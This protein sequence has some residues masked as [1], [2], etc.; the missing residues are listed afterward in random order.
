MS[1]RDAY[2]SSALQ[3][4]NKGRVI[5]SIEQ[6]KSLLRADA[7]NGGAYFYLSI[8][9]TQMSELDAAE[10]YLRRAMEL[11][12]NQASHYYQLGVIRYR[13]KQW[14]AALGFFNQALQFKPGSNE[15]AVWRSIGDVQVE[16]FDRAAALEAYEKAVA[17]QPRDAATQFALGR[18]YLERSEPVR[19]IPYLRTAL[20][21]DP[22]LAAVYPVLGRA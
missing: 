12:P 13:Q 6:L 18:F 17:V 1:S 19:A 20:D 4:L 7:T 15:A 22:T 2:L 11:G 5:E 10:R 8:V 3:E 9:Y 14:R 21:V 16:L